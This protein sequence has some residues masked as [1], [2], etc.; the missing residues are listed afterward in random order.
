MTKFLF[1]R[2]GESMANHEGKFIGHTDAPLHQ[3]GIEQ[4]K[5]TAKFVAQKYKVDKIYASDLSRAYNTALWVAKEFGI[6]VK[7]DKN[8]RE[9]YAG[10]WEG[11][12][13]DSLGD[14]YPE[15]Y[16]LWFNEIDKSHCPGGE[17][18]KELTDRFV[19]CLE[20]IA[21][22]C[23]GQTVVVASHATPIRVITSVAQTGGIAKMHTVP[24]VS[25]ASVTEIEYS[26]GRWDIKALSLDEHLKEIK[27]EL[28]QN[29]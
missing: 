9:L 6:D 10:E 19:G 15:E 7:T 18:V 8:L 12:L 20:K 13:F 27:T 25:N 26:N 11:L 14:L 28:P 4:A 3:N 5:L 16:A 23:D 17:S 2:H 1:I 29:V 22:E 21:K 24:W